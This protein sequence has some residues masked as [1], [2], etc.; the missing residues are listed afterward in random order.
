[1]LLTR[2]TKA[3]YNVSSESAPLCYGPRHYS[4]SS[5]GE[6]E[7]KEPV[8]RLF[9]WQTDSGPVCIAQY[10]VTLT[11]SQ[12]IAK[13]P[14]ADATDNCNTIE[15]TTMCEAYGCQSGE[16]EDNLAEQFGGSCYRHTSLDFLNYPGDGSNRHL[17][18]FYASIT[19]V[20]NQGWINSVRWHLVFMGPPCGTNFIS[21]FW[22]LEF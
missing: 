18:N 2:Y 14:V 12:R 8:G 22:L 6:N 3:V 17:R 13:Q 19:G 20:H 11:V 7:L 4:G 21:P 1:M 16:N 9:C 15:L 10:W 5:S